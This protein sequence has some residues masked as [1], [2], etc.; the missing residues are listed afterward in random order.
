MSEPR[1]ETVTVH[2]YERVFVRAGRGPALLL[3]HGI[4]CDHGSWLPVLSLLSRHFTVILP[5]LLGHGRSA[6]PRADYSL[7]GFANGMRDL[8]T[9]LGIDRVTVGG[10]SFGGG[11]AMQ[12]AYQFP[13]R[14][15]RMILVGTGGLG[16]GVT[17]LLRALTLP[18]AGPTLATITA[19]PLRPV[20][21]FGARAA[22]RTHLPFTQDL[23]GLAD[24]YDGLSSPAARS[25]FLHV[26]RGCVDWRGQVVSMVDRSYLAADMPTLLIWGGR[27]SVIPPRHAEQAADIIPGAHIEVFRWSGHFPQVDEPERF[28]DAIVRFVRTTE[29][30]VHDRDHWRKV[31]RRGRAVPRPVPARADPA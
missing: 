7:G 13:E 22:W 11:V 5:D 23:L 25:A 17:P 14:T 1:L 19:A 12:F 10:N 15:E 18:G 3:I 9:I 30:N 4:G 28:A 20:V 29:P 6:K 27:D 21:R 16:Q 24:V 26:L 2:G 8:L 31:L